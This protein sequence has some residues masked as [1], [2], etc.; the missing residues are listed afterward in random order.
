MPPI[1]KIINIT[2]QST[3]GVYK[4]IYSVVMGVYLIQALKR[5]DNIQPDFHPRKDWNKK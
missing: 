1:L 4:I 5:K 3:F 2:A